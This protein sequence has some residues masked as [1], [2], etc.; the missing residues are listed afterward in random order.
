MTVFLYRDST[1]VLYILPRLVRYISLFSAASRSLGLRDGFLT[2]T[3]VLS[4][5]DPSRPYGNSSSER[6]LLSIYNPTAYVQHTTR[7]PRKEQ[8]TTTPRPTTPAE[9]IHGETDLY[10]LQIPSTSSALWT[11]GLHYAALDF[12]SRRLYA[13]ISAS[14]NCRPGLPIPLPSD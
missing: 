5:E 8:D 9:P 13:F 4:F 10:L 12:S 11:C 6:C 1:V 14:F 3:K 7:N 2:Q